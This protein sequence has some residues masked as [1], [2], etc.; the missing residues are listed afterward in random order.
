MLFI[1]TIIFLVNFIVNLHFLF[2]IMQFKSNFAT[3]KS[4]YETYT[5]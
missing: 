2:D 5:Y 4:N 3:K 1:N